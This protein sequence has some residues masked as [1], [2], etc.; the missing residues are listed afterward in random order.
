MKWLVPLVV[1][2]GLSAIALWRTD[3]FSPQSIQVPLLASKDPVF[4]EVSIP[5]SFR[6]L[7]RGRQ[8]FV[9]ES[10]DVVLKLFDINDLKKPFSARFPRNSE[11]ARI[12]W[13]E[14]LRIYPESYPLAATYLADQTGVLVVHL[15]ISEKKFPV[16][17][18][19]DKASRCFE[20]DLNAVPFVIQK[21]GSG[22]F[23]KSLKLGRLDQMIDAYL[24]FHQK[25]I[26]L[27]IADHDRDIKRNYCWNG[28][29]LQYIDPA[30]IFYEPRMSDP[31]RRKL[32]WWKATHR[33]RKW[34]SKHAPDRVESFDNK[35]NLL[36]L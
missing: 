34:L 23:Y 4:E 13:T 29:S 6:Y 8:A 11:K 28:N 30:R 16:V 7:S 17:K 10:G 36:V 31:K 18:L 5:T 20:V 33:L 26:A 22:S 3:G 27:N 24:S 35:V 14:K 2:L 12:R 9:F 25:R 19:V 15:G 32:E 21:K 1:A